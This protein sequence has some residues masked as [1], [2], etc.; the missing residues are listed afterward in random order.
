MRW[1]E[2]Q[3]PNARRIVALDPGVRTFMTTYDPSGLAMEV[4]AGD[5][6]RVYRL[7]YILDDLMSRSSGKYK[8]KYQRCA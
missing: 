6:E 7:C 1:G 5:M 2:N 3:A 4:G 8:I